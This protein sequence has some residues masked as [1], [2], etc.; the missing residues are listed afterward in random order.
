V[1]QAPDGGYVVAGEAT[2]LTGD[3]D[4]TTPNHG[5]SDYW[6]VKLSATGSILWQKSVGGEKNEYLYA[7]QFTPD[8]GYILAGETEST[9]G[10]VSGNHGNRD[11]WIVKLNGNRDIEWQK[12]YGGSQDDEAYSVQALSD[13]TYI[14]AGYTNSNDGNITG[15][16]GQS[17]AW[18][19]KLDNGGSILWS[20]CLGGSMREQANDVVVTTDGGYLLAGYAD[21]Q[22]GDVSG[23]HAGLGPGDS[24]FWAVKLD[25]TGT[26]KWQKCYGGDFNEQAYSVANTPDGGYVMAGYAQSLGGDVTC[27]TNIYSA[28]WVIKISSTGVLQWEKV[29]GGSYYD[30]ENSVRPTPDG[31]VIVGGYT[32]SKELPGYHTDIA[33]SHSIGDFYVAKLAAPA[34]G[35][36]TP[37]LAIDPPALNICSGSSVSLQ[38]TTSNLSPGT[39]YQWMRN[40]VAVGTGTSSYTASDFVT[41]DQVFCT[42]S[43]AGVCNMSSTLTSNTIVLNV[44]PLVQPIILIAADVPAVCP[45]GTINFSAAVSNGSSGPLYQ[46]KVNGNPSGSN[47]PFYAANNLHA[48]DIVSCVYS[49]NTACAVTGAN[50]SN[51]IPVQIFPAVTPSVSITS[52]ATTMCAGSLVS[53]TAAAVGEGATPVYQWQVNGSPVGTNSTMYSSS[54]L[55][56]GD[57]VSC[58]LSSSAA[59]AAPATAPSNAIALKVNAVKTSSLTIDYSPAAICSGKPV[60]FTAAAVGEGA[61]P[62]YQWQVNGSAVGTNSVTY[63]SSSLSDGDVVTCQLSDPADCVTPSSGSVQPVVYQ[64]PHLSPGLP[65]ILSKGQSVTL[66]LPA[67]GDINSYL[68]SPSTDLSDP[69]ISN[70]VASPLKTTTYTLEV[71]SA[72]GCKDE[73]SILVSVFSKLAIP[74]AF[75]P[76][77]DGRNDVFYVIGGPLG[78]VIKDFTVFNRWGQKIFLVH[79]VMPDDPRYGWNGVYNGTAAPTGSYVYEIVIGFADGTQQVYRGTV[80]LLR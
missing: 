72:E 6:I 7:F 33:P 14:I 57:A 76:N 41:G 30:E 49:D 42:V 31:G 70:P 64:T 11:C 66:G 27:N 47:S 12:C 78:S 16:H 35:S 28:G 22:D 43:I 8:G 80:V 46:W 77:G 29:L 69:M 3:G 68:W 24:D 39:I 10:D 73:G 58:V 13:G 4:V 26:V 25:N 48:D 19:A 32:G 1:H 71:S 37:T 40:G 60:V 61:T 52:S 63:S 20:K 79:N 17:D 21:S 23:N 18:V 54:S 5:G 15:N 34:P 67:T 59:C 38:T 9:S 65:V 45:G 74:N 44:S 62:L 36:G 50:T 2:S 56:D 75:T 51:I 55:S 53:F